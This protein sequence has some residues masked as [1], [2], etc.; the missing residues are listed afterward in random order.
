M[1]ELAEG[2]I[3][4]NIR[5]PIW[6]KKAER[7]GKLFK[8][9]L[10]AFTPWVTLT[11]TIPDELF[12]HELAE[13]TEKL[14]DILKTNAALNEIPEIGRSILEQIDRMTKYSVK[15]KGETFEEGF[16]WL[17]EVI[18]TVLESNRFCKDFIERYRLLIERIENLSG[19]I[20]FKPLYNEGRQLFSIGFKRG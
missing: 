9:E 16:S 14:L 15:I 20:S 17:N 1:N 5:K 6:K 12:H 4:A 7:M 13:E 8:E 2:D 3:S 11:E 19:G 18:G 10:E